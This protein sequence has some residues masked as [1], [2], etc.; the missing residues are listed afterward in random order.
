M[1]NNYSNSFIQLAVRFLHITTEQLNL[2]DYQEQIQ[3]VVGWRS[4]TCHVEH[5]DYDNIQ[6]VPTIWPHCF[7]YTLSS[8]NENVHF[9]VLVLELVEQELLLQ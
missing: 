5:L 9:C 6:C 8:K 1:V 3:L 4:C 7:L 2:S